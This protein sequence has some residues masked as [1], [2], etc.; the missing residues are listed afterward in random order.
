MQQHNG[1]PL[2]RVMPA[3]PP[4]PFPQPPLP[5]EETDGI[6]PAWSVPASTFVCITRCL[7]EGEELPTQLCAAKI[8][9]NVCAVQSQHIKALTQGECLKKILPF[10]DSERHFCFQSKPIAWVGL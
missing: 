8:I 1:S 9:E 3:D 4:D 5:Q 2:L 7:R 10:Y 6:N